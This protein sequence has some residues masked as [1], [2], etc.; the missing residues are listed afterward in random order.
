M[1]SRANRVA[2]RKNDIEWGWLQNKITASAANFAGVDC[3][4]G[5]RSL[6]ASSLGG[7]RRA[8]LI[9]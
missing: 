7:V 8:F 9:K 5:A 1:V 6:G 2:Y 4:G 3:A